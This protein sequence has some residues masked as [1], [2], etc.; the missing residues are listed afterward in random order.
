MI[1]QLNKDLLQANV[2]YA[3]SYLLA[4][5]LKTPGPHLRKCHSH[6]TTFDVNGKH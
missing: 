6:A 3:V 2:H 4:Y 5:N 1:T